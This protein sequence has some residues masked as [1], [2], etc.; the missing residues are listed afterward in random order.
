MPCR[1]NQISSM[2]VDEPRTRLG[3]VVR[4]SLSGVIPENEPT[5]TRDARRDNCDGNSNSGECDSLPELLD[6]G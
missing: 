4:E 3:I 2:N 6:S 1:V 5:G